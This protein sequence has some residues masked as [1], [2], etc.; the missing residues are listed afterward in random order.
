[1][2]VSRVLKEQNFA[3]TQTGTPYY[4]SPEIW[5]GKA[6]GPKC[7]IWSIGCVIYE[8]AAL[9]PPFVA[10]TYEGLFRK[11]Q[12]GMY[13]RIEGYSPRLSSLIQKCLKVNERDRWTADQLLTCRELNFG[14]HSEELENSIVLL[15]TIR[16]PKALKFLNDHL[17]EAQY[18][19]KSKKTIG[20]DSENRDKGSLA[21]I[22]EFEPKSLKNIKS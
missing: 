12:L 16:V 19:P 20:L 3:K 15:E 22:P 4:T 9:R 7:D 13:E 10:Q 8:M 14:N 6:Y 5:Q 18:Q 17:P 1:M 21:L 2:N 11:V